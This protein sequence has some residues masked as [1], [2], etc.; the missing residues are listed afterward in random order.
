MVESSPLSPSTHTPLHS[1]LDMHA[2]N[3]CEYMHAE[4][5][6]MQSCT[7]VACCSALKKPYCP[8]AFI[9]TRNCS[10]NVFPI[11]LCWILTRVAH[12]SLL[13]LR[14]PRRTFFIHGNF[15]FYKMIF[16]VEKDYSGF[17]FLYS[18]Q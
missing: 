14:D 1:N 16:S 2:I 17:F 4:E 10:Q 13:V 8:V 3:R 5:K 15:S 11:F 9:L 6:H 12:D 7:K 18:S